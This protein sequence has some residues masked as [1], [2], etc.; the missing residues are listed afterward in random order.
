MLTPDGVK[1]LAAWVVEEL[2]TASIVVS[3]GTSSAES[4]V[5]SAEL[6]EEDGSTFAQL[7]TEFDS[8]EA[9]F[10]WSRRTVRLSDGREIDAEE[11][12]GGRKVAGQVWEYE[13]RI[14]VA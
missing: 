5:A 13:V 3:D 10:E 6:V 2:R 9:N 11:A 4:P 1:W 8:T 7:T 14:K 12:D